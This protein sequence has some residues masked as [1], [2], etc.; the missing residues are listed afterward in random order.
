MSA[1]NWPI[2]SAVPSLPSKLFYTHRG[3]PRQS[4]PIQNGGPFK[5]PY[6]D[7]L[8]DY[9]RNV[10]H[11]E[12]WDYWDLA[13]AYMKH[14]P[15]WDLGAVW[16]GP[17]GWITPHAFLNWATWHMACCHNWL[18]RL[19]RQARRSHSPEQLLF[20]P[21]I[22]P[23]AFQMLNQQQ[24]ERARKDCYAALRQLGAGN[25]CYLPTPEVVK[26]PP[27]GLTRFMQFIEADHNLEESITNFEW[28]ESRARNKAELF[29]REAVPNLSVSAKLLQRHA[30]EAE[31]L[32]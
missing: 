11:D 25:T 8:T 17:P 19:H 30:G 22:T 20:S 26:Y 12:R 14:L 5:L 10:A 28:Y 15:R 31:W 13:W 7:A 23:F 16:D 24:I 9:M 3:R 2:G 29:V 1:S 32:E 6:D 21:G 27:D 4:Y 18:G